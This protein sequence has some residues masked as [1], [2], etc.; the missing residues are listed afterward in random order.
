MNS[1]LNY[2]YFGSWQ[3]SEF[4]HR[5]IQSVSAWFNCPINF[6]SRQTSM[7]SPQV[8]AALARA[9]AGMILASPQHQRVK[10]CLPSQGYSIDI[11]PVASVNEAAGHQGH[12]IV[13][14]HIL[15]QQT[16]NINNRK[17]TN[18]QDSVL[19]NHPFIR[20]RGVKL[21]FRQVKN[22]GII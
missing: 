3:L 19:P 4:T 5:W 8:S 13:T 15:L 18:C 22:S 12:R 1:L 10:T 14:Q 21:F 17:L 16:C 11:A 9:S 6:G 7:W 20:P 2:S